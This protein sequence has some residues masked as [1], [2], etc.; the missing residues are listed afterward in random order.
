MK[1]LA[2]LIIVFPFLS[3]ANDIPV[4]TELAILLEESV[5]ESGLNINVVNMTENSININRISGIDVCEP[6]AKDNVLALQKIFSK[7]KNFRM[8]ISTY[9]VYVKTKS[10]ETKFLD[11]NNSK[12]KSKLGKCKYLYV[13][14][15]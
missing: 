5:K 4:K 6:E 8:T 12:I 7:H 10:G 2:Y 11:G 13:S 1:K 3:L 14:V 15:Y 9:G